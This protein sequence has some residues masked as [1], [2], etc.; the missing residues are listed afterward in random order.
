MEIRLMEDPK[1]QEK[2]DAEMDR[3]KDLIS[4]TQDFM[5][6]HGMIVKELTE[7]FPYI[8]LS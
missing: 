6:F 1:E 3:V 5:R 2:I 4:E 7:I 8:E